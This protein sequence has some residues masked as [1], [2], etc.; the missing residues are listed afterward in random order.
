MILK[1]FTSSYL[2][3]PR[4]NIEVNKTQI[5]DDDGE[6]IEDVLFFN[7]ETEVAFR[8]AFEVKGKRD[9]QYKELIID[10]NQII[11]TYSSKETSFDR[12]PI[13]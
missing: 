8:R 9:L 6:P 5:T 7:P 4:H 13:Y 2:E 12:C 1:N 10:N 3:S 11:E